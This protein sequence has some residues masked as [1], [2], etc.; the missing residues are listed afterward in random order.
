MVTLCNSTFLAL[1]VRFKRELQNEE[2]KEGSQVKLTC[3][4]SKPGIPVKWTKGDTVL[5]P[6]DKYE[7]KQHGTVAELIIQDAKSIDAGDYSCSTGE[8]K[9]TARVKVNGRQSW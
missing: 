7:L 6:S 1:P 4:L 3:E 9:T 8:Q 2:A 5:E